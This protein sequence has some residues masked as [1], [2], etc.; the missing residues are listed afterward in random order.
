M[1]I[2]SRIK[3][4]LS[5]YSSFSL[6][7]LQRAELMRRKDSKYLFSLLDVPAIL[8]S[9]KD[10]YL[11]LEVSGTRAQNYQTLYYDTPDLDM[12]HMHHRGMVNRHK[13]RFRKYGSTDAVFLEVKKKDSKGVTTKSRIKTNSAQAVILSNEEEFLAS[14]SPYEN[15]GMLPVLENSFSR[16]ALMSS[17]QAER[18]T[19]DYGLWFS[20]TVTEKSLE[21][22][23]ISIAEIKFRDR[24]PSSPFHT[25][26]RQAHILP[27]RFSKYCIG[28]ALLNPGLKQ[29]LF[30]EKIRRVLQLNSH[31][32]HSLNQPHHA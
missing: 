10:K 14:H 2:D 25:A 8:E 32:L 30:K 11:V 6:E 1:S 12:Y 31:Y 7:E 29:N 23:G 26:L 15:R 17:N 5:G 20:S 21:L 19:I 4:I 16:I 22:P 13:V 28:M 3:K 18:I 9:V 24:L 27:S